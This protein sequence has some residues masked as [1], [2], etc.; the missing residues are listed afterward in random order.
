MH[1]RMQRTVGRKF[2]GLLGLLAGFA[3]LGLGA[4]GC[5]T[6]DSCDNV[7]DTC[8]VLDLSGAGTFERLRVFFHLKDPSVPTPTQDTTGSA[9]GIMLPIEIHVWPP[10][11]ETA[12]DVSQI[13][14]AGMSNTTTIVADGTTDPGFVWMDGIRQE[15]SLTLVPIP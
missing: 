14:V 6:P 1:R 13:E 4:S 9:V 8:L 12:A 5:Y 10:T 11:H 2:H 3:L 15:T 7:P